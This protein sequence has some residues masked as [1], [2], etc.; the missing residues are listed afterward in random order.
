MQACLAAMLLIASHSSVAANGDGAAISRFS[1]ASFWPG[2]RRVLAP[3]RYSAARIALHRLFHV[4][5]RSMRFTRLRFNT[6]SPARL[7][8]DGLY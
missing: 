1:A 4:S 5:A 7:Q 6:S 3:R 8:P 2:K